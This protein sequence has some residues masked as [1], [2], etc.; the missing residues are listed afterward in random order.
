MEALVK[1]IHDLRLCRLPD[2]GLIFTTG[3]CEGEERLRELTGT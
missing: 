3:A 1:L 2:P